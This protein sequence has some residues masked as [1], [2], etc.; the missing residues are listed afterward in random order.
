[1]SK[2]LFLALAGALGTLARVALSEA[3]AARLGNALPWGTLVV[4]LLG[5]ALFGVV[6]A[7]TDQSPIA[8]GVRLYALAGFMGAFTTFSSLMFDV[9]A[10]AS[11]GRLMAAVLD[12]CLHNLLGLAAFGLG[13]G[14]GRSI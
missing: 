14:L 10:L 4:N 8:P 9:S 5:S 6:F 1:M 7:A 2:W 12:L 3:V 11:S 13:L